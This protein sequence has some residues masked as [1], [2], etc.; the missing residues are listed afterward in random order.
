MQ[1]DVRET[2]QNAVNQGKSFVTKQIDDRTTQIGQQV[3]AVG[4]EIRKTADQLRASGP[5]GFAADYVDQAAEFVEGIGRYLEDADSDRLMAD[6]ENLA[7]Q[8]PY[9]VAA[10]ALALGFAA[11]RFLRTSSARRYR[12]G[13][14]SGSTY[15][16]TSYGGTTYGGTAYGE[17]TY[18]DAGGG[19]GGN[20][21]G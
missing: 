5:V 21:A 15:G 17:T 8:Q 9:V 10:A 16:S 6:L 1:T 18:G 12:E 11:S 19:R 7:R 3:G 4:G 14:D 2:A 13:L 20:R